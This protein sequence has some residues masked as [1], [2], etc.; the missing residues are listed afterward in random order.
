MATPPLIADDHAQWAEALLRRQAELVAQMSEGAARMAAAVEAKAGP[1]PSKSDAMAYARLYRTA[2][3]GSLLLAR[4]IREIEKVRSN[5]RFDAPRRERD[6]IIAKAL[7]DP[8]HDHKSRVERI[9]ERIATDE[10]GDDEDEIERLIAE[11]AERL[12]DE[13]IYRDVRTMP[14]K[15]LVQS[16]CKD[17]DL[18]ERPFLHEAWA[19]EDRNLTRP[20]P[21]AGEGVSSVA[22]NDL[23]AMRTPAEERAGEVVERARCATT[24]EVWRSEPPS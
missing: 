10:H 23:V 5:E 2:R 24:A 20:P 7:A 13:D 16:I 6:A 22:T 11:C 18:D 17:L 1:E 21:L 8:A 15:D 14:V 19:T 4:L 12:D 9:V 3:M